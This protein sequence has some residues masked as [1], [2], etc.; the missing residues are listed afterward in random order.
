MRCDGALPSLG[1]PDFVLDFALGMTCSVCRD[2]TGSSL[3][4]YRIVP[5][6]TVG[7]RVIAIFIFGAHKRAALNPTYGAWFS[8]IRLE[9]S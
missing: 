6:E 3:V 5:G 2:R 1:L 8:T 7:F 9:L 4:L